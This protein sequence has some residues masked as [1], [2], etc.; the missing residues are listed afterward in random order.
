GFQS[1]CGAWLEQNGLKEVSVAQGWGNLVSDHSKV[2]QFS[3]Q[4]LLLQVGMKP[5]SAMYWAVAPGAHHGL[6]PATVVCNLLPVWTTTNGNRS[7]SG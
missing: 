4:N 5:K 3:V 7:A 1:K 6:S 2:S